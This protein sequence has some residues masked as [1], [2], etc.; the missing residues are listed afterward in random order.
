VRA[1]ELIKPFEKQIKEEEGP[2]EAGRA[3]SGLAILIV[4]L[5]INLVL[6]TLAAVS[7]SQ[8]RDMTLPDPVEGVELPLPGLTRGG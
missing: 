5:V 3:S 6:L 7:L 2:A 1:G 4:L 8:L